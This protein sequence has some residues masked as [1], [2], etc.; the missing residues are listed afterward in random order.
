[1]YT[2]SVWVNTAREHGQSNADEQNG[3]VCSWLHW[4]ACRQSSVNN[5][6][7]CWRWDVPSCRLCP[8]NTRVNVSAQGRHVDSRVYGTRRFSHQDDPTAVNRYPSER[9]NIY[10]FLLFPLSCYIDCRT[11]MTAHQMSAIKNDRSCWP[12]LF[13]RASYGYDAVIKFVCLSVCLYA[14][15]INLTSRLLI[16][17]KFLQWI[18]LHAGIRRLLNIRVLSTGVTPSHM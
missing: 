12:S 2:G 10:L 8:V 11:T 4:K 3:C 1:M 6:S 7:H 9:N 13:D 18:H 14:T 5:S 15:S 16:S 17:V